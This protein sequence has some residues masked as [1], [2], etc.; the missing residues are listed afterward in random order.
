MTVHT[1]LSIACRAA[2][3][4]FVAFAATAP[5][6]AEDAQP[7]GVGMVRFEDSPLDEVWIRSG[8]DLSRYDA[9]YLA[10][11]EVTYKHDRPDYELAEDQIERMDEVVRE[12][13]AKS[14]AGAGGYPIIDAPRAGAIEIRGQIAE[15]D[16]NASDRPGVRSYA[17]NVGSMT[18]RAVLRDA[19][20]GE[21][22]ALVRDHVEGR[23]QRIFIATPNTYWFEFRNAV[24]DWGDLLR[25][26]LDTAQFAASGGFVD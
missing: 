10:P 11:I 8:V 9:I 4:S 22:L 7:L 13:L 24:A 26:R 17:K 3:V 19:G 20:T 21:N 18:L 23:D 15:L 16:I 12:E 14:L 25:H 6:H 2:A 1:L 5:A